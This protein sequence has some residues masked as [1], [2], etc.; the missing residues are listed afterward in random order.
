MRVVFHHILRYMPPALNESSM[1]G[2]TTEA[3]PLLDWLLQ[4]FPDT[5][6]KRAKQ[7][8]LAGR[9]RVAGRVVRKPHERLNDP[10]GELELVGDREVRIECDSPW[11][12]HPQVALVYMDSSLAIVN[13]AAGLLSVPAPNNKR[14]ALGV[15]G[16]FLDGRLR[17]SR[18]AV[19]PAFRRLRPLPV[20]RLDQFTSGLLCIALNPKARAYLIEQFRAHTITRRYVAFVEGRLRE[21]RGTWKHWLRLREDGLRQEVSAKREHKD[22]VLAVTRYEVVNEYALTDPPGP[23]T[24][25][26]LTLETGRKHQIRAQAAFEGAP[27]LGDRLYNS[28]AH[29]LGFDRQALHAESLSIEH[30]ERPGERR[31]WTAA[32]PVDLEE[33][34]ATCQRGGKLLPGG[35]CSGTPFTQ[36]PGRKQSPKRRSTAKR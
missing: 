33:L 2:P 24:K 34:E 8:I 22:V 7:W 10:R 5:A 1:T 15:L 36:N 3:R 32:L 21:T 11:Q 9:V 19:P 30:P 25:L 13:K 26:R 28:R 35:R 29:W 17:A 20:H 27:L 14:S 23:V 18:Y 16:D 6:R 4:K 12:I 31:T